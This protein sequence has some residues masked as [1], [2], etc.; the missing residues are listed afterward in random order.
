VSAVRSP[1]RWAGVV[2]RLGALV[3]AL[4]AAESLAAFPGVRGSDGV[5][6]VTARRPRR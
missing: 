3:I 4:A 6:R 2:A 5:P 1:A